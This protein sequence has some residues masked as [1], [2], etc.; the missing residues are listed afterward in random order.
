M[1]ETFSEAV[2]ELEN[3]ERALLSEGLDPGFRAEL[4]REVAELSA[5]LGDYLATVISW[6]K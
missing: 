2:A 6:R 1:S 3:A 5:E 4:E